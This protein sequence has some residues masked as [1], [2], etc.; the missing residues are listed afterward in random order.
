MTQITKYPFI[1]LIVCLFGA[2]FLYQA[3]SLLFAPR[4]IITYPTDGQT[5]T[6][7]YVIIEGE[8]HRVSSVSLNGRQIFTDLNGKFQE[9][10]LLAPGYNIIEVTGEDSFG[11]KVIERR[12]VVLKY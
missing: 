9:G 5:L 11:R 4:I 10:L 8:A 6:H 1:I 2:Y 12:E 7:S 3:R